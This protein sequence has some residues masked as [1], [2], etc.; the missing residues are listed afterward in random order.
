MKMKHLV[1]LRETN[2]N[3]MW[4]AYF[5]S[6]QKLLN[7]LERKG[8]VNLKLKYINLFRYTKKGLRKQAKANDIEVLNNKS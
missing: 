7:K 1:F 3:N 4:Q 8:W 2:P 5:H 6:E